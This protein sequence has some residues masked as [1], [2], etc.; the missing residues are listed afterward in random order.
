MSE[1]T[2]EVKTGVRF[3]TLDV[4]RFAYLDVPPMPKQDGVQPLPR[5]PLA[6]LAPEVIDALAARW[7]DNLYAS[8][9]RASP[10]A[11]EVREHG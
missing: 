5:F 8:V 11:S 4:P 2:V 7:L 1:D 6:D 9:N 10:F 3:R